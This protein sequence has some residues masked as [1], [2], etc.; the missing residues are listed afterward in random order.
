M[1]QNKWLLCRRA[2]AAL[3]IVAIALSVY[4]GVARVQ[5]E[6]HDTHV[7]II[8]NETDVRSFANGNRK[9]A[10]EMLDILKARG[11][12]QILFKEV[13]LAD[14]ESAGKVGIF[15]GR[16]V[17]KIPNPERLSQNMDINDASRYVVIYDQ[18]WREQIVRE[19]LAKVRNVRL[20]HG[21]LDVME[22]PS[23]VAQTPLETANAKMVVDGI[24]VGY[25]YGLMKEVADRGMGVIP[26]VR[27]WRAVDDQSI[28]VLKE[29]LRAVPNISLIMMNDK[30][31]PG[32]PD[33]LDQ[34][35][36]AFEK[37]DGEPLAPLGIVEF[38]KQKG[39]ERMGLALGKNVVRVHTI[40]NEEMSRFEGDTEADRQKGEQEALDRWALAAKE[41][42][43]RGL[44][45]RFFDINE[46]AYSLK[47]NLA[48][49][50]HLTTMLQSNGFVLGQPYEKMGTV[51]VHLWRQVAIG[52]GVAGG[53]FLLFDLL[54]LSLLGLLAAL[55]LFAGWVGAYML[56][57]VLATKMM[58]LLSVM[59]FPTLSCIYFLSKP[60][61]GPV[62]A[63][64]RLLGM[65]AVSF[66]GAVLMV[67]LLS[68]NLFMLKLD[69]FVGVKLAH[70]VPLLV[71]P[72]VIYL[73]QTDHPL[74]TAKALLKKTLDYKWSILFVILAGALF[75][76]ISRTGNSDMQIS[77]SEMR[78]RQ[79]LTD[80][81]G[82]R[83]RSKEFLI[84][85]PMAILFMV[86][87]ARRPAFWICSIGAIIG[88]VSLVNTYAH[89]HTPLLI[90]LER[91]L[92]GLLLGTVVGLLCV[93]MIRLLQWLWKR[94]SQKGFHHG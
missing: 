46:P 37:T 8:V 54:G 89:I 52:V 48:Y 2:A 44:L 28:Q 47:T 36:P 6:A 53:V 69:Q 62:R 27:T 20:Y 1:K 59:V 32:Y 85:Y 92:N 24:G 66:I 3:V 61:T 84:G 13:S 86:F 51:P 9:T 49:L 77:G 45:V 5:V 33:A 29:D 70:V 43:M 38:S 91:S 71:V 12:S 40:T 31:V 19:M 34:V 93:V 4:V 10:G 55:L 22:V 23:M 15:Q 60:R 76:Y 17:L 64:G 39:I 68:H 80:V 73:W 90:S 50:D 41:R 30:N 79:F 18:D 14:L 25:D 35:L 16:N 57:P 58:A 81:F 21:A 67:G 75:I 88:Q 26:Q 83:P 42:N 11:V 7:N 74:E 72:A 56:S 82:V 87:G 65:C 63:V 78:M 94:F